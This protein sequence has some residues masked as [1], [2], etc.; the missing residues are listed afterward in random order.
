[1]KLTYSTKILIILI[2]AILG[3]Y[4][5]FSLA[6]AEFVGDPVT[7]CSGGG[8]PQK[9]IGGS[10]TFS[11]SNTSAATVNS[12]GRV[13][14]VSAG[15]STV[16]AVF[17]PDGSGPIAPLS[18]TATVNVTSPP[19]NFPPS[20]S[21]VTVTQ[22]DYCVSGPAAT[23]N[24]SYSDPDGDP[25][26][27]FQVQVDDTGSSWNPPLT[28]D[29][30]KVLGSGTSYFTGNGIPPW[31][32]NVT[33]KARVRVWDSNDVVSNWSESDTWRTPRHAYPIVDFSW[34]PLQ[35]AANQSVQFTDQTQ[36]FDGG[37]GDRD[38][39][40]LFGDGNSSNNE[41]PS[42]TYSDSGIFNVTSTVTDDD[43]FTCAL[44]KPI[45]I[46]RPIPTWKEVSPK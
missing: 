19:L 17:D 23:V 34:S 8:C 25:Q 20:A 39:D 14:A 35:P 7:L 3:I 10:I 2:V 46:E 38:W 4:F 41:N 43:G 22:P 36:F 18:A 28:I 13:A 30:G 24:W 27:A 5:V 42:H 11:S 33:Y 12:N 1:M 40:W 37:G 29:S 21:S 31:V 32:W 26:T 45:G 9:P 6:D 44:T 15:S 16:T